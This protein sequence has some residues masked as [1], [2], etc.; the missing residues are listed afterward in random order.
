MFDLLLEGLHL[1]GAAP[2]HPLALC[3]LRLKILSTLRRILPIPDALRLWSRIWLVAMCVIGSTGAN[4]EPE[5]STAGTQTISTEDA[6]QGQTAFGSFIQTFSPEFGGLNSQIGQIS[7][8]V[9]N[10]RDSLSQT[11]SGL[12]M[13]A[14]EFLGVPYRRGG[15][16]AASGFDCSG[17]VRSVYESTLGTVLP[18]R[19]AE[20]AQITQ[21]IDKDELRPGDLVFFNTMRRA[22]SHVGIYVGDG[23]FI[24]SPR[25]GGKVR[26]ESMRETYWSKRFDGARRVTTGNDAPMQLPK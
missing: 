10:V 13:N 17:F 2:N 7:T 6:R 25:V 3:I 26:V 8:G 18:R 20:Q 19:A 1:P 21:T 9:S 12:V 11:T 5:A 4:A 22:F 15:S 23:N 14:M 24:H 16:S